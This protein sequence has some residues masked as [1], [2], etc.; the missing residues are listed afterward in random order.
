M[1]VGPDTAGHVRAL[2]LAESWS[3]MNCRG[4]TSTPS[5]EIPAE[6]RE[7]VASFR[8]SSTFHS[9]QVV[10]VVDDFRFLWVSFRSNFVQVGRHKESVTHEV[11]II[12]VP[13]VLATIFSQSMTRIVSPVSFSGPPS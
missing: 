11:T 7:T 4:P 2:T 10:H 1:S 9:C 12:H 13:H 6:T 8:T 5:V 3:A